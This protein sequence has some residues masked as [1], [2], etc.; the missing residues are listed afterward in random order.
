VHGPSVR[1]DGLWVPWYA[2]IIVLA[3]LRYIA[4]PLDLIPDG[5]LFFG[6]IDDLSMVSYSNILLKKISILLR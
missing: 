1:S 5:M 2:R 6:Q 4:S 3:P